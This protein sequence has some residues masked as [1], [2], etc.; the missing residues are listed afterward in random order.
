MCSIL[1]I[2]DD[3]TGAAEIA[4]I[5]HQ[6][7][8]RAEVFTWYSNQNF[9]SDVAI[10]NSNTRSLTANEAIIQI[11]EIIDTIDIPSFNWV[12]LK[13]DSALRGHI[14][15]E[16]ST[17]RE[18]LNVPK[19]FFCPVN[20]SLNRYI[21]NGNYWINNQLISQT[22]FSK[23]PEFPI[24]DDNVLKILGA[25]DWTIKRVFEDEIDNTVYV[26]EVLTAD[27]INDLAVKTSSNSVNAGAAAY[28]KA[29]LKSYIGENKHHNSDLNSEYFISSV[30]KSIISSESTLF[31]CGSSH[32]NSRNWL[33]KQDPQAVL[34]W[35]A[36]DYTVIQ[37][38]VEKIKNEG[39]VILAF[40]DDLDF[41]A[42]YLR[43]AMAKLVKQVFINSN[44]RELYI[45]GGATAYEILNTLNVQR[46]LPV[47]VYEAG[48]IRMK[49]E[50][51][52]LHII[53]KPGS[54]FW[55]NDQVV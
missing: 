9:D 22:S 25:S 41:D 32:K 47:H 49:I 34:Y 31:V 45:E 53:L 38:I 16:I 27:D 7:G 29:L 35:N 36:K 55:S 21:K 26:C 40:L 24:L 33:H 46:M 20:P 50:N 11:R 19:I 1:V 12:Y 43:H 14:Y 2:A 6:S 48:V 8:L 4:G 18:I 52:E 54:Y 44:L 3:L 23:D 42:D 5:V 28:F 51:S 39:K 10:V 17:Y 37:G 13:F 15:A 30:D